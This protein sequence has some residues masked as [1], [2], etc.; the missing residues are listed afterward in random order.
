MRSLQDV[1]GVGVQEV[2]MVMG[3]DA[4]PVDSGVR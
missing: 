2:S 1:S 3:V 4:G